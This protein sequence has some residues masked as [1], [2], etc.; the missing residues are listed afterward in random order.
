M[1]SLVDEPPKKKAR[2]KSKV[3]PAFPL[4]HIPALRLN[5]NSELRSREIVEA[6]QAILSYPL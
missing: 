2:A 6:S 3:D 4:R 1:S 5:F